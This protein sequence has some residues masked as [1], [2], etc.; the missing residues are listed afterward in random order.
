MTE[1]DIVISLWPDDGL[2][3][4]RKIFTD[5]RE[6]TIDNVVDVVSNAYAIHLKNRAEIRYLYDFYRGKQDIRCKEKQVRPEINNKVIVNRANEIVTFKT[7]YFLDQP[8]QY[9]SNGGDDTTSE[10]VK[11]FNDF[12]IAEDKIS[13]DKEI[14]DWMNICGVGVRMATSKENAEEGES[15]VAIYSLDPREAFVIYYSGLG[16][17]PMAGVIRQKGEDGRWFSAVYTEKFYCEIKSNKPEN[18]KSRTIPYIPVI[19]YENNT[20]RM[21][22]FEIVI[23]LLNT[24]NRLES[25]RVDNIQDFVNAFDVFQNCELKDGQYSQLAQG[26]M[27][28][29]IKSTVPGMESKVY[30]ITSPIDQSGVQLVVNDMKEAYLEICGM[31]NRNGGS[32]TS[33]TGAATIMRDGWQAA[34]SRAEDTEK[35]FNKPERQFLKIALYICKTT[36][37]I[38][39]SLSDIKIE[40]TRNNLSNMQSRMQILCEGLNNDKIHPKIPWVISGMP[41]AEEWYRISMENYKAEQTELERQLEREQPTETIVTENIENQEETVA[42]D[43]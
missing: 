29:E 43:G 13:L 21:G 16:H 33:D 11:R 20:A 27:A 40:H 8:I 28:I 30:R 7:A 5:K 38:D 32:S 10:R 3:G 15:P 9:I 34:E 37:D 12:M 24:I 25:E 26:G 4:R 18:M 42:E 19:E 1:H 41:N 14:V 39:L 31:P 6:I 17:K 22:A 23:P 2:H 36:T 35:S